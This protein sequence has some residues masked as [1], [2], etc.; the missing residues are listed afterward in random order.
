MAEYVFGGLAVADLAMKLSR[1]MYEFIIRA[2][3]A[4]DFVKDLGRKFQRFRRMLLIMRNTLILQYKR[5]DDNN[6]EPQEKEIWN[7]I[8]MSLG[9]WK[10]TL[11][12]LE[13][14]LKELT[15]SMRKKS[16]LGWMVSGLLQLKLDQRESMIQKLEAAIHEHYTELS[17]LMSALLL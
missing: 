10:S 8:Q 15:R 1:N 4:E 14:E 9:D 12:K 11:R 17:I 16:N 13:K 7:D 3:H 6:V 2:K 5:L